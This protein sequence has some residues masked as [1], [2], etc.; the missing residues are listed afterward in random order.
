VP[1]LSV[2]TQDLLETIDRIV[3]HVEGLDTRHVSDLT[4]EVGWRRVDYGRRYSA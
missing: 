4:H 1:I 3:G 2:F